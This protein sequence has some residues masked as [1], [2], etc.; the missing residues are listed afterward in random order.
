MV[1]L[2]R[3]ILQGIRASHFFSAKDIYFDFLSTKTNDVV[4]FEQPGPEDF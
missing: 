1:I 3:Y 4:S 2:G